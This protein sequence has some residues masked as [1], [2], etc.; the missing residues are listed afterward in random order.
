MSDEKPKTVLRSSY[1]VP[2]YLIDTVDLSFEL[3]EDET[4]VGAVLSVRRR[5]DARG[6]RAARVRQSRASGRAEA[7]VCSS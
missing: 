1:S 7:T 2:D 6:A 3:A 5:E 4:H